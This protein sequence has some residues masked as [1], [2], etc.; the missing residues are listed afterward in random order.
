M[1]DKVV[2]EIHKVRE[3]MARECEFDSEK[4]FQRFKKEEERLKAEEWV[5]REKKPE[6]VS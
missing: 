3:T 6:K 5:F 1:E 2:S 4:M